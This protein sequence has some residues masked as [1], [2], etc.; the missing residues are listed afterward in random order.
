MRGDVKLHEMIETMDGDKPD[1]RPRGTCNNSSRGGKRRDLI[2]ERVNND[3]RAFGQRKS[4]TQARSFLHDLARSLEWQTLNLV[5]EE[6]PRL[7]KR[8]LK[9][10]PSKARRQQGC[11]LQQT[12]SQSWLSQFEKGTYRKHTRER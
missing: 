5:G 6:L 10:T 9:L 2:I 3:N 4:R 11:D 8:G 1:V 7:S 12:L